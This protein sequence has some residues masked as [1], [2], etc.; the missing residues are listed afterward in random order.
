MCNKEEI[1]KNVKIIYNKTEKFN[2]TR[3]AFNFILPLNEK[4][5]AANALVPYLLTS[6]GKN[7]PDF[8]KLNL[9]LLDLYNADI[10][11]VCDF[12]GDN[13]LLKIY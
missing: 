4:E 13:Q 5:I 12:N 8:Q 1:L 6:C 2:T 9:K 7:Y 11:A 10:G 3:I